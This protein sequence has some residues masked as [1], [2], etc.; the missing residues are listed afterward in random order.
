MLVDVM[1]EVGVDEVVVS[2]LKI[3][4][5]FVEIEI[6]WSVSFDNIFGDVQVNLEMVEC[7]V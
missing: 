6:V 3:V 4:F 1:G 5:V 2:F 7:V